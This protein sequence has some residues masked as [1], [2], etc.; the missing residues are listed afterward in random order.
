MTDA[1]TTLCTKCGYFSQADHVYAQGYRAGVEEAA[2]LAEDGARDAGV[3]GA[4]AWSENVNDEAA[5]AHNEAARRLR[6]LAASIRKLAE[7][8]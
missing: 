3:R 7:G 1:K 2:Q 4:R 6:E 5:C 8:K